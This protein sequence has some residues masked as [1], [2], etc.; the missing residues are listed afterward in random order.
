MN[1]KHELEQPLIRPPS[2]SRSVLVRLT[3]GCKWNRCRFCGIYPNLG[4]PGF[5]VRPLAEVKKDI[6][7][8]HEIMPN[9][10]TAFI[11][12]SDPLQARL[13]AFS[14][15]ARYLHEKFPLRRLTSYARASTLCKMNQNSISTLAEAGLGRVH[16]GLE[17]GDSETLCF[18]KK[19]QSPAMVKKAAAWLKEAGIEISF[20]VLLGMAGK[21]HWERHILRT[22]R[23][24][25]ETEPEFLRIRRLWLYG[26]GT[27]GEGE[28]PLWKEIREGLF[29]PQSQEGSVLE[30]RLL[31]EELSGSLST[32][33]ATDHVNNYVQVAGNLRE[34]KKEMLAEIDSFL[35]LPKAKREAHYQEV[36][37]S[38]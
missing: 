20:Y 15:V 21:E 34:D 4:E 36:G 31:V 33:L 27:Y 23:L 1:L 6:D 26:G 13:H 25:N 18:H 8:L 7:R 24:V 3:R 35:S 19:G 2:E 10:E 22:A 37:S 32:Y 16:I 17:S 30:L 28:C 11:G 29:I 5:S 9:A 38:I 12:D 14:E